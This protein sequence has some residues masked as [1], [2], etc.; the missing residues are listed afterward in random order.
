MAKIEIQK[1]QLVG[2]RNAAQTYINRNPDRSKLHYALEKF[3]KNTKSEF[4]EY[5]DAE[6][7]IRVDCALVD[8]DT[9]K[10]VLEGKELAI[11][12]SKA[13]DLQKKMRALG[14]EVVSIDTFYC[15]EIPAGLEAIWYQVF[16][17]VI[18]KED[19]DPVLAEG[20]QVQLESSN[21]VK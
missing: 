8:K 7:D 18:F 21:G 14:R 5:Q 15:T 13:K 4:E 9:K 20:K 2:V 3:L 6:N 17:G 11:D 10:F 19:Q 1:D 16:N 12:P